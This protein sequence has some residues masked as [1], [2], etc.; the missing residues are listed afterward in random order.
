MLAFH[1]HAVACVDLPRM[2]AF[3]AQVLGLP[4]LRRWP[5]GQGGERSLW[6]GVGEGFLALER[7]A[8]NRAVVPM[9]RPFEE[10]SPGHHLLAL[11]I[12]LAERATWRS[13]LEAAGALVERE[14]P[15]SLFFRDPEGN[16]LALSH[17]PDAVVAQPGSGG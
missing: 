1:H 3:Y 17:H 15:Y 13:R 12:P 6:L 16:R 14:S 5:D 2:E 10:L 8:P 4:V 9:P 7:A 11:R